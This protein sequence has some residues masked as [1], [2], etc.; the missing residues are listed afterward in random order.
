MSHDAAA[1]A[2]DQVREEIQALAPYAVHPAAGLIKLDAMENPYGWPTELT[3]PWLE[4][5]ARAELN[6]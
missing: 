3:Q 4:A 5:I 6:R 1:R 2:R